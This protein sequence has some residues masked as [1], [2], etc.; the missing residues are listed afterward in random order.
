METRWPILWPKLIVTVKSVGFFRVLKLQR[1]GLLFYCMLC[2]LND[3]LVTLI[4]Y[5]I[6]EELLNRVK[7]VAT[8]CYKL[9]QDASFKNS[10]PVQLLKELME[11]NNDE[12][13]ENVDWEDVFLLSDENDVEWPSNPGF[14]DV[15]KL[16]SLSVTEKA[17]SII[18][19]S[20]EC[21]QLGDIKAIQLVERACQRLRNNLDSD[22]E[23]SA[24][25]LDGYRLDCAFVEV[26]EFKKETCRCL[27]PYLQRIEKELAE[28]ISK[29]EGFKCKW[30]PVLTQLRHESERRVALLQDLRQQMVPFLDMTKLKGHLK[31]EN[32]AQLLP[33]INTATTQ[34]LDTVHPEFK[35]IFRVRPCTIAQEASCLTGLPATIFNWRLKTF[36]LEDL[37][38]KLSGKFIGLDNV[39]H[40]ITGALSK[41][42]FLTGPFGSFLLLGCHG[43]GRTK[44]AKALAHEI[45]GQEERFIKL[46]MSEYK[47]PDVLSGLL[48]VLDRLKK[49]GSV[50]MFDNIENAHCSTI[51]ILS[52]ILRN[53]RLED[54]QGKCVNFTYDLILLS[55]HIGHEVLGCCVCLRERAPKLP[56][57]KLLKEPALLHAG[58]RNKMC[59]LAPFLSKVTDQLKPELFDLVDDVAVFPFLI[60]QQHMAISRL[61][62]RDIATSM[63]TSLKKQI[64]VYP[65]CAATHDI[66]FNGDFIKRGAHAYGTWLKEYMVPLLYDNVVKYE[67]GKRIAIYIDLLLGSTNAYCCRRVVSI[68][69][70]ANYDQV[71]MNFKENL[72]K[73]RTAYH[74]E[75]LQVNKMYKLRRSCFQLFELLHMKAETGVAC[76]PAEVEEAIGLIDDLL[77]NET[78]YNN[79]LELAPTDHL[80][81]ELDYLSENRIRLRDNRH[82]SRRLKS[83][84][85]EQDKATKV[86]VR[87]LLSRLNTSYGLYSVQTPTSFLCLGLAPFSKDQLAKC[88]TEH[89]VVDDGKTLLLQVDLSC[90]KEPE[91]FSRCASIEDPGLF[92]ME[93]VKKTPH[94][95]ILFY[96][97]ETAHISVFRA[98]ISIL[99]NGMS[100]D[101]DG[102]IVDFGKSVIVIVSDIWNKEIIAIVNGYRPEIFRHPYAL[103]VESSSKREEGILTP[104]VDEKE[105]S[106]GLRSELLSRLDELLLFD[107]LSNDQLNRFYKLPAKSMKETMTRSC[108]F[109][110]FSCLFD[111]PSNQSSAYASYNLA[112]HLLEACSE[113]RKRG[114]S[115]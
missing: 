1:Y 86:V 18:C 59:V 73:L 16:L 37:E 6:S 95:V 10:K 25:D 46:D 65:S 78:C 93:A 44:L 106:S 99:E 58:R 29:R 91:S 13:I 28:L 50:V 19:R 64:I 111:P 38:S 89:L 22:S 2:S 61:Q 35:E 43:C 74:R 114:K 102:N 8:E 105:K 31:M 103:N 36:P 42:S 11:K 72:R 60:P 115:S 69:K 71:H 48:N 51:E 94:S 85:R 41:Q 23:E 112:V 104:L 101:K 30:M 92:L 80:N 107:P 3:F 81:G 34:L 82:V 83:S 26:A 110:T 17:E 9:E 53:R 75:R 54:G 33:P 109:I 45:F 88:L 96:K 66:I 76:F 113:F 7:K 68:S 27:A 5:G 40:I 79:D 15:K 14:K 87:A 100:M 70:L 32:L 21:T 62:I 12:K 84:L 24:L 97:L 67:A 39:I 98:L 77:S 4:N 90:C 63:S 55:S 57:K 49:H 52:Q 108:W 47:E 20:Y 56:F